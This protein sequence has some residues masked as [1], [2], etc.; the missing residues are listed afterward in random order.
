MKDTLFAVPYW[1][2]KVPNWTQT[3]KDIHS[4]LETYPCIEHE[5]QNFLTNRRLSLEKASIFLKECLRV[6]ADP[7]QE[8]A[9]EIKT[10]LPIFRDDDYEG[11]GNFILNKISKTRYGFTR[12]VC[13]VSSHICD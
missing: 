2:F 13:A 4:L 1:K 10:N 6:F 7:L 12:Y 11:I 3:K 5:G 9:Q 8:F